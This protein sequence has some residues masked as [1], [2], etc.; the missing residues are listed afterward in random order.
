MLIDKSI[1]ELSKPESMDVIPGNFSLYVTWEPPK[2]D[3]NCIEYYYVSLSRAGSDKPRTFDIYEN[4]SLEIG[5][6]HACATYEVQIDA[7]N[8]DDAH[9]E[10][11]IK[12][13]TTNPSGKTF[14]F[15]S[16]FILIH[17]SYARRNL[18]L[19]MKIDRKIILFLR[20][21]ST[22]TALSISYYCTCEE[23]Y[24]NMEYRETG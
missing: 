21:K 18:T 8:K 14:I 24:D 16:R 7:V 5:D 11:T 10:T 23:H 1:S 20:N 3:T 19:D 15:T 6:L 12:S 4:T 2:S 22:A 13:G 17:T 9:G